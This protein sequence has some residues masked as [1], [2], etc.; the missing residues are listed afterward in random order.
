MYKFNQT[1]TTV[2]GGRC[3][4]SALIP[5]TIWVTWLSHQLQLRQQGLKLCIY[6][7]SITTQNRSEAKI[8]YLKKY[9]LQNSS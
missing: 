7:V 8:L 9:S 2:I 5:H 3:D 1:V 6:S 4:H